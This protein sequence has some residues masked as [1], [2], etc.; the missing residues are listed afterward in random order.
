MKINF[1][2]RTAVA[3]LIGLV[4][5]GGAA[6]AGIKYYDTHKPILPGRRS[7][8]TPP[9]EEEEPLNENALSE[10]SEGPSDDEE[11]VVI[12]AAKIVSEPK[13]YVIDES[14]FFYGEPEFEK[15]RDL[16]WYREDKILVDEQREIVKHPEVI[17][18]AA[19]LENMNYR[20]DGDMVYV[21]NEDTRADY[22]IEVDA[23]EYNKDLGED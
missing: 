23:G 22:E 11:E 19:A 13:S 3:T 12:E 17:L 5:G 18:G 2:W 14:E 6:Y 21:R 9:A 8:W 7:G 1:N 20:L 4:C 15:N 10:A 16:T